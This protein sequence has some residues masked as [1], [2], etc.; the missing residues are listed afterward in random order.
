MTGMIAQ[1]SPLA[2]QT[3][4][5]GSS[6]G[7]G[8]VVLLLFASFFAGMIYAAVQL[9]REHGGVRIKARKIVSGIAAITLSVALFCFVRWVKSIGFIRYLAMQYLRRCCSPCFL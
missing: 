8:S 2:T 4:P 3:I 9:V 1:V 7:G 5:Q 6:G